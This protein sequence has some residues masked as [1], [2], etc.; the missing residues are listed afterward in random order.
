MGLARDRNGLPLPLPACS[1]RS[2]G[3][4]PRHLP[5]RK[6]PQRRHGYTG[7]LTRDGMKG[8][9]QQRM[10]G[11][12][13]LK[14]VEQNP[15]VHI[16]RRE[17]GKGHVRRYSLAQA[18][19][20]NHNDRCPSER[21]NSL[22]LRPC[23]PAL[24][25][26]AV[27]RPQHVRPHQARRRRRH[28]ELTQR[29]AEPLPSGRDLRHASGS[30]PAGPVGEAGRRPQLRPCAPVLDGHDPA[31]SRATPRQTRVIHPTPTD[32]SVGLM[33]GPIRCADWP[34]GG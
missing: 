19:A 17:R 5:R 29:P 2:G 11:D 33:P 32:A 15:S 21:G 6:R 28:R 9:P 18:G 12:Q 23:F 26:V 20:R 8:G 22:L 13:G 24:F 1:L 7:R 25:H 14:N 3:S 27:E 31:T 34:A 4:T 10:A 30:H 16:L